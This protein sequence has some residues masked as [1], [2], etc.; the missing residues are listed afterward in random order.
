MLNVSE[1]VATTVKSSCLNCNIQLA[2]NLL[3]EEGLKYTLKMFN[4]HIFSEI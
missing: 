1:F 2:V 4:S 3:C